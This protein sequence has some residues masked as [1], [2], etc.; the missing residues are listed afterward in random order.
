MT[1]DLPLGRALQHLAD[2]SPPVGYALRLGVSL[3]AAL[4]LAPWS[5]LSDRVSLF[6]TVLFVM[7][8][9]SGAPIKQG[10]P[11]ITGTL[12]RS[13]VRPSFA[14]KRCYSGRQRQLSR[15]FVHLDAHRLRSN[16]GDRLGERGHVRCL[17]V[18]RERGHGFPALEDPECRWVRD[19]Q[20]KGVGKATF[21]PPGLSL[22]RSKS[23][24]SLI[25]R[26]L[27]HLDFRGNYEHSWALPGRFAVSSAR[28]RLTRSEHPGA[29]GALTAN[30]SAT[31][32]AAGLYHEPLGPRPSRRLRR[33]VG[34]RAH[35]PDSWVLDAQVPAATRDG[36][37]DGNDAQGEKKPV[38]SV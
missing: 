31:E 1:E 9:N 25:D 10:I 19:V 14:G 32:R 17:E 18:R 3:A 16:L 20:G 21:F 15:D 2:P 27:G 37:C 30:A 6:I 11:R 7:P 8:P 28:E 29:P 5:E 12:A 26:T 38:H 4:G 22:H 35:Q 24:A 34:P 23:L 33:P 36:T 13:I